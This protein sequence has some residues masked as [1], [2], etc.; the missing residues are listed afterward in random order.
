MISRIRAIV[1]DLD[2]TLYVNDGFADEI[3]RGA[4]TYI[5]ELKGITADAADALIRKTRER[6]S[7][8]QGWEATLSSVCTEL[9]GS[10]AGFHAAV[11]PTLHPER[12]LQEDHRVTALI[13]ALAKRFELYLYT[14]NNRILTDRILQAI[15]LSGLFAEIFTIEE[16]WRP[17]PDRDVLNHIFSTIHN[18]PEQCLFVG[19]RY[20][21]DLRL[22]SE[23]CCQ[24]FFVATIQDLLE[25]ETL[26]SA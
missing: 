23:M 15:G 12:L 21:V 5:A 7:R 14:N 10:I 17:K 4:D 26:L 16:F 25:L 8:K 19:D 18:T 24:T 1:F 6:L 22:P 13:S 9:G 2:G 11:T 20:D 3:K